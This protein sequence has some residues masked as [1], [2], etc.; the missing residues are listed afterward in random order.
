MDAWALVDWDN[1]IRPGFAMIDWIDYLASHEIIQPGLAAS[2][3]EH[4]RSW[5]EGRIDYHDFIKK[6]ISIYQYAEPAIDA[7]L[8][9]D[10]ARAFVAQDESFLTEISV[11]STLL[12]LFQV[13]D[14]NVHIV[15]GAPLVILHEYQ[16]RHHC[17]KRVT[18]VSSENEA[19]NL[20]EFKR[21]V[22]RM[23]AGSPALFGIGDSE[24]DIPLFEG[25]QHPI[26]IN[27]APAA[28]LEKGGMS[29]ETTADLVLSP[30]VRAQLSRYINRCYD[31][32]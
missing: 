27:F 20:F 24:T 28:L 26:G 10:H 9:H 17:I 29:V 23:Y 19:G 4:E 16:R 32:R 18:G 8:L 22:A 5:R 21:G 31:L 11:G 12:Q 7:Q 6:I 14:I 3:K 15:S 25:S 30:E 1:T 2:M 13:L